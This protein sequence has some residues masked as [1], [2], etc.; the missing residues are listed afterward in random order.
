MDFPYFKG[1]T[2]ISNQ[3]DAKLILYINEYTIEEF[4]LSKRSKKVICNGMHFSTVDAFS[5]YLESYINSRYF[6]I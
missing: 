4:S 1:I 3:I 5:H 2:D 6:N